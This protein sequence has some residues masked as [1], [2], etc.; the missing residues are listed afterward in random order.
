MSLYCQ[1]LI[2]VPDLGIVVTIANNQVF[3]FVNILLPYEMITFSKDLMV[4]S[5]A[6]TEGRTPVHSLWEKTGVGDAPAG[7]GGEGL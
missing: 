3:S 5:S 6:G 1:L 4:N 2:V 7:H